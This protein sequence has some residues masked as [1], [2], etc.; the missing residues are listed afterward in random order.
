VQVAPHRGFVNGAHGKAIGAAGAF[1]EES[2]DAPFV[3]VAAK[4]RPRV[5]GDRERAGVTR[6]TLAK[7]TNQDH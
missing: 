3:P 4:A 6:E 1:V 2:P 5:S 7:L